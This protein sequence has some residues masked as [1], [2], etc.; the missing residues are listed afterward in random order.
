[1]GTP[2]CARPS[3][4]ATQTPSSFR[5][6]SAIST[7]EMAVAEIPGQP[8]L[9]M[10]PDH[11]PP[12]SGNAQGVPVTDDIG[13]CACDHPGRRGVGVR[14]AD[15]GVAAAIDLGHHHGDRIPLLRAI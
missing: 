15:P 2:S 14:V 8:R 6:H 4:S 7:A 1:M 13:E 12:A 3:R 10:A 11:R 9:R 5:S